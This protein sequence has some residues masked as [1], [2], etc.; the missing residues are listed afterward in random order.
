MKIG[1]AVLLAA[2]A[3]SSQAALPENWSAELVL[4]SQR[5]QDAAAVVAVRQS[6]RP[7]APAPVAFPWTLA[8]QDVQSAVHGGGHH[9]LHF[10]LFNKYSAWPLNHAVLMAIDRLQQEAPDG[11]G[12]FTGPRAKPAESPV[13]F[14]LFLGG[15]H[16]NPSRKRTTSFCTGASYAAFI[17]ALNMRYGGGFHISPERMETLM[18]EE[19]GGGRREDGVKFWGRW[20]ADDF[21]VYYA[22]AQYS[23]MG[24]PIPPEQARA[25]DFMTI[26]WK[27]NKSHSAVFLGWY[28]DAKLGPSM[29]IWSSQESTNGMGDYRVALSRVKGVKFVRLTNPEAIATFDPA[30]P[31]GDKPA[32]DRGSWFETPKPARKPRRRR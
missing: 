27:D 14:P 30:T 3:A 1:A 28:L 11:G 5:A 17:M 15:V 24:T 12:Y 8:A 20:N 4:L 31:A 6:R 21:G 25:G 18:M 13:G 23:G 29:L 16:L 32:W 10:E 22:L 9:V 26:G 19:P 7:P 2:L